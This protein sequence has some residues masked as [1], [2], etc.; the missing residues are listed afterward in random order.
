MKLGHHEGTKGTEPDFSK[1]SWGVT[2]GSIKNIFGTFLNF[3]P[4]LKIF[5]LSCLSSSSILS[6]TLQKPHIQEKS[7]SG[8]LLGTITLFS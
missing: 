1:K 8:Y 4:N 5:E 3:W 7:G 2:N 6:N